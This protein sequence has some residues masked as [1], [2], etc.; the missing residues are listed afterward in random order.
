MVMSFQ[1]S[2]TWAGA[3][4]MARGH[5][6]YADAVARNLL[7]IAEAASVLAV[8][9]SPYRA[10]MMAS[11]SGV[12]STVPCPA[13]AWSEWPWVMTACAAGPTGSMWKSPGGQ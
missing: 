10:R 6:G 13:R 3:Q 9:S 12:A 5:Q 11:V 7:A 8:K 2:T 4:H 1:R